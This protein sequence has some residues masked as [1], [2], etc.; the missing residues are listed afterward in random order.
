MSETFTRILEAGELWAYAEWMPRDMSTLLR[1]A[2]TSD[3]QVYLEPISG[4]SLDHMPNGHYT[5]GTEPMWVTERILALSTTAVPPP[6]HPVEGVGMRID[7]TIYWIIAPK[8][9]E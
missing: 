4:I 7:E 6:P 3:T 5:I 1:A 9:G 2:M 8:E